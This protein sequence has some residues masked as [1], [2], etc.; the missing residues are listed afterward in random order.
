MQQLT[1][2]NNLAF[3]FRGVSTSRKFNK[4]FR[5]RIVDAIPELKRVAVENKVNIRFTTKEKPLKY[6]DNIEIHPIVIVREG[7]IFKRVLNRL[8][9]KRPYYAEIDKVNTTSAIN[10][11]INHVLDMRN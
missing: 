2:N 9:G 11:G 1:N 4:Y 8:L 5:S 3:G 10:K 6:L 7:S